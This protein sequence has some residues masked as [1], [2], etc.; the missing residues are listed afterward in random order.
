MIRVLKFT[1]KIINNRNF[2]LPLSLVL[3][4]LIRD[5]GSWIKYLTIPALAVVMIASLTQISFKTFFKFR[6]LLKPVLY[7]I[8]FNYFIFGAVML[9][10][11]WFLVPDRQ[12]WIGFVILASAPPGVAIAPFAYIIGGDEKFSIIGM[13]GAYIAAV[14]LIPLAGIIFVGQN[15]I[16]PLNLFLIIIE[17]IIA[18]MIISQILIK[19]KLDKYISKW[20]GAIINWGLF[21]VI[22]AVIALNREVFFKDFKTLGIISLISVVSVFGLWIST[23][24]IL[25]KLRFNERLR[26]SLILAATIKNS[27]F[28]AATALALF[29]E[30][31]SL[32]GAILSVFLVIF[33]IVIGI[34]PKK[35]QKEHR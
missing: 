4:L 11:A 13:V 25:K 26:K 16:Q 28:A 24:F 34:P 29:G 18:P 22:F 1:L 32:P 30:K 15:F 8:L 10:L 31:A 21:I 19:F 6:E 2:I 27:G 5:I 33:L 35:S 9:V 23:G 14:A 3:G 7:T 20:R 17:L 12:L